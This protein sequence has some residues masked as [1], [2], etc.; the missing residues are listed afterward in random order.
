MSVFD[1]VRHISA[2]EAAERAGLALQARGARSWA[3]CPASGERTASLCLYPDSGWHCFSCN[4]GGDAV[5]LYAHIFGLSPLDAARR[6]AEDFGTRVDGRP[7]GAR[8]PTVGDVRRGLKLW[9]GQCIGRLKGA[10]DA[11]DAIVKSKA[12]AMGADSWD[13]AE[14]KDMLTARAWAEIEI[15]AMECASIDELAAIYAGENQNER[16]SSQTA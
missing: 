10:S 1:N 11:A 4:A 7:T 5:A 2:L 15:S 12:V 8:K 16:A 14:F 6:L 3:R 13:N 9:R